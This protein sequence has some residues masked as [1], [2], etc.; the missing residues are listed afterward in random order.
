[1]RMI[2][3]VLA[4]AFAAG[5]F[6]AHAATLYVGPSSIYKTISAAASAAK[7]G[8]TIA[9]YPGTYAGATISDSNIL[10]RKTYSAAPGSVVIS[11]KTVG[12]KGLFLVKG[13]N[14]TI[15]GL[16]FTGA[17][18]TSGNGAGIRQEGLNLTVRNSSFY[19]NEMGILATPY[20]TK[21]GSLTIENSSFD[22][23]KAYVSGK[24]GHSVYGNSLDALTVKG[25]KFTRNFKGHYVKSR[26]KVNSIT[27]NVI[28]DTNGAGSYLIDIAEGG[29][30]TI[31]NNTLVKGANASNCCIAI[32]YGF[33]MYKGSGYQ[34]A[35]GPVSIRDNKFTNKRSSGVTFVSNKSTPSNPVNLYGNTLSAVSGGIKPLAGSGSVDVLVM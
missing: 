10:I 17:R 2:S 26:A 4:A 9:I 7:S 6:Q 34:N 1:M 21:G 28:D 25:S 35:P 14:V 19:N 22:Y 3:F 5:G 20:P 27:G 8:D 30:A 33:E 15:D 12:D 24:L 16:R 23:N 29:A 31:A 11:G 13:S 32:A 18:S